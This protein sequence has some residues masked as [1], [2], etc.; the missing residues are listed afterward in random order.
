MDAALV[1]RIA[2]FVV[3]L[4]ISGLRVSPSIVF[5]HCTS[6]VQ[7]A[8]LRLQR[9]VPGACYLCVSGPIRLSLGHP[10]SIKSV[11]VLKRMRT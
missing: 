3:A 4:P 11:H 6:S 9:A 7:S 2:V 8:H 10:G 5:P 1:S